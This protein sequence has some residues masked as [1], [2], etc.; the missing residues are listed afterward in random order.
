MCI[1]DSLKIIPRGY[2]TSEGLD[3]FDSVTFTSSGGETEYPI[4]LGSIPKE[5][6]LVLVNEDEW[7]MDGEYTNGQHHYSL[8]S[9]RI[10]FNKQLKSGDK[11]II[12]DRYSAF[13]RYRG[14]QLFIHKNI[15]SGGYDGDMV[16]P[17]F[18]NDSE[19]R[20]EFIVYTQDGMTHVFECDESDAINVSDH[21]SYAQ[22]SITLDSAVSDSMKLANKD[23]G[24][25]AVIY[26][27]E[28]DGSGKL[29]SSRCEFI[30]YTKASGN[31]IEGIKRGLFG[32][33]PKDFDSNKYNI[34]V[35]PLT[36]DDSLPSFTITE[37][38]LGIR[39]KDSYPKYG[40]IMS[41]KD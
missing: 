38:Y 27:E 10:V 7:V 6:V 17:D 3:I 36:I 30:H 16:M 4:S 32:K 5:Q 2:E 22:E 15:Q 11:V 35:Y 8:E 14:T 37:P 12:T 33:N 9:N 28:I 39:G 34:K 31:T 23:Q 1:R 24:K 20:R 29:V 25:I 19:D 21:V 13:D 40:H 41:G 26:G 18:M